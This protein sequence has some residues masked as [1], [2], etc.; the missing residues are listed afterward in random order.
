VLPMR[1]LAPPPIAR[2][3]RSDRPLRVLVAEDNPVNQV[4]I[5]LVLK[6]MGHRVELA[7]NGLD[8]VL[9]LER[10]VFD[11]VFMDVHMPEMDGLEATRRIV[12]KWPRHERPPIFAMTA[13]VLEDERERCLEVGMEGFV[14]KPVNV[15]ELAALLEKLQTR[16]A[17]APRG[18][19]RSDAR[20]GV[21][22][23]AH[24]SRPAGTVH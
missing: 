7:G 5:G 22:V 20:T 3:P 4:V 15:K 11:V 1:K 19:E 14:T 18:A 2:I 9:A 10:Q 21:E 16:E 17:P 23:E 24:A 8:A 12:E 6:R 13:S